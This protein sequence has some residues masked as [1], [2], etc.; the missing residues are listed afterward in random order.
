[1]PNDHNVHAVVST[2]AQHTELAGG[3]SRRTA[4]GVPVLELHEK[5]VEK[6]ARAQRDLLAPDKDT[7]LLTGHAVFMHTNRERSH[8]GPDVVVLDIGGE[9]LDEAA[10]S[11]VGTFEDNFA[12]DAPSWVAST[13][14][15]LAAVIASH[16]GCPIKNLDEVR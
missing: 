9:T 10:K 6:V 12:D 4:N 16:Y 2:G 13:D 7:V 14:D 11:C 8:G 3:R 15:T 5:L 1:M